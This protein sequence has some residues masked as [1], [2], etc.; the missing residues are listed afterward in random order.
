[1]E[2]EFVPYKV[3]LAL[4]ELGFD[5]EECFGRWTTYPDGEGYL[6]TIKHSIYQGRDD[7]NRQCLAP[8][9]Q[10]AFKFFREKYDLICKISSLEFAKGGYVFEI[11]NISK[12]GLLYST[13]KEF[14]LDL[15]TYE[16]AELDCLRI[17][18]EICKNK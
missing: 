14:T 2:N 16:E 5:R 8:L 13:I 10:Q 4:K 3:A 6:D 12:S 11:H 7:L 15:N 18:I 9:Y 1:M 17:L